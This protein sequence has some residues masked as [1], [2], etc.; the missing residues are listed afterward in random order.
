MAKF[1]HD[2]D[3]TNELIFARL[4][5]KTSEIKKETGHIVDCFDAYYGV[6]TT[7]RLEVVNITQSRFVE[8]FYNDMKPRES[9]TNDGFKLAEH[10]PE[11]I[12]RPGKHQIGTATLKNDNSKTTCLAGDFNDSS[13]NDGEPGGFSSLSIATID[14]L[15]T[16]ANT[17][18]GA[19]VANSFRTARILST[20]GRGWQTHQ[21]VSF[22]VLD[23]V[24]Q[25]LEKDLGID[26]DCFDSCTVI[27]MRTH[28]VETLNLGDYFRECGSDGKV[29]ALS[30]SELATVL[31]THRKKVGLTD[32]RLQNTSKRNQTSGFPV[33]SGDKVAIDVEYNNLNPNSQSTIF[34]LHFNIIA[35]S[36]VTTKSGYHTNI[37]NLYGKKL[38]QTFNGL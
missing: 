33:E 38:T 28:I 35:D 29:C 15:N 16:R 34:R 5:L 2:V 1:E 20:G 13:G 8:L 9:D 25:N 27:H 21:D 17:A 24:T 3:L 22:N 31:N 30:A 14:Q 23:I 19:A 7:R 11:L 12:L 32:I 26:S 6:D 36:D 4:T 37:S 10:A 18:G